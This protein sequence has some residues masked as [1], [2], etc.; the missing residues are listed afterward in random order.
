MKFLFNDE[1]TVPEE[2]ESR[3]IFDREQ[4]T[5]QSNQN[6]FEIPVVVSKKKTP[7]RKREFLLLKKRKVLVIIEKEKQQE[8]G[9]EQDEVELNK[10]MISP[11]L[12]KLIEV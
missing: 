7:P 6:D 2:K 1:E 8:K 11:G 4:S 10:L 5:P 3:L 12:S 9:E